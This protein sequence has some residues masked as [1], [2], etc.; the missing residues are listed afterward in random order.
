MRHAILAAATAGTA[1]PAWADAPG[2]DGYYNHMWSGDYGMGYG[3]FGM[4]MMVIF[5]VLII[6]LAVMA[7]RWI[8]QDRSFG[9]RDS[10]ALDTLKQRL[11]RGEIDPEEYAA[12]R[13]AL[14][15]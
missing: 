5:W 13:K 12:R 8:G 4:G 6:A 1:F 3:F 14:E 7:A 15:D 10:S 11:A 2:P 9:A